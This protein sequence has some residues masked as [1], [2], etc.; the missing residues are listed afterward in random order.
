MKCSKEIINL[1]IYDMMKDININDKSIIFTGNVKR[2]DIGNFLNNPLII[3]GKTIDPESD[4]VKEQHN[5]KPIFYCDCTEI[6]EYIKNG[7]D[8]IKSKY[9]YIIGVAKIEYIDRFI[10]GIE[11]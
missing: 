8:D 10:C 9:D 3:I 1:V 7:L 5:Y 4:I 6:P 2:E 11:G